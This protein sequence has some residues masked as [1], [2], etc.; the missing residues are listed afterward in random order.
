MG[1]LKQLGNNLFSMHSDYIFF[2]TGTSIVAVRGTKA[3]LMVD[4]IAA[5]LAS[6]KT[7]CGH[8]F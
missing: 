2:T 6:T 3:S 8:F 1:D 5:H 4:F 7:H